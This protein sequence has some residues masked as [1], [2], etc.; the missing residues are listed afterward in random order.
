M[1]SELFEFGISNPPSVAPIP[2]NQLPITNPQS[3]IPNLIAGMDI[4]LNNLA[5]L[6]SNKRGFQPLLVK[7]TENYTNGAITPILPN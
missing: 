1:N 4:G 7:G 5:V 3:P 6:T 2:N